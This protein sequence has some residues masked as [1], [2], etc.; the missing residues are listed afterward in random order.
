[1][2]DLQLLIDL[3]LHA[4]RQGP[5]SDEQT[6]RAID[7]S[8]LRGR[9]GLEIADVGCGTGA[10]T[11]ILARDL[12]AQVAAV[13]LL[14]EF[15]G[16]LESRAVRAGV[17]GR[18]TTWVKPMDALPFSDGSLDAIWSEGAVYNIG[19]ESGVRAWRRFLRKDGVLAVSELTW[20]TA[21]RPGALED[22]WL[23][24]YPQVD[25]ASAKMAVLERNGYTPLAYFVLPRECWVDAYYR[26]MQQRFAQFLKAHE[27]SQ[28][29]RR[30]VESERQEIA[31]YER[32][33]DHF[34]YGFYIARKTDAA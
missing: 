25:T 33:H 23:A 17:A 22:H 19:F 27:S 18:I 21:T 4:Q 20:L 31:L 1:L 34:G 5:G 9:R 28:A 14:P 26:P 7:L 13:D 30:I 2:D 3:H 16:M 15:V 12:D 11:L 29:A 6:R 10:S 24:R 8:G 32:Y